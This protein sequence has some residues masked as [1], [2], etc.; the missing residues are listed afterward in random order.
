MIGAPSIKFYIGLTLK[1]YRFINGRQ[2][3]TKGDRPIA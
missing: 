1:M 3:G 2:Y